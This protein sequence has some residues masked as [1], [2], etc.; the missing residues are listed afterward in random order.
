LCEV[1]LVIAAATRTARTTPMVLIRTINPPYLSIFL[2][3]FVENV[4]K[5]V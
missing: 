2:M 3:V 1:T 5:A 4:D